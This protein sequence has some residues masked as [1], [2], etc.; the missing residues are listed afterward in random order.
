MS[1]CSVRHVLLFTFLTLCGA[2]TVDLGYA[3][4]RG[5]TLPS[6]V[7]EYLGMRYAAPPL[8]DRRWRAPQD[9]DPDPQAAVQDAD[10]FGASCLGNAPPSLPLA[11]S[12]DCLFVNVFTPANATAG[13]NLPV[14]FFIQGGGFAT[15]TDSVLNGSEV[16]RRSHHRIV[17]VG[18]NYRVGAFGFLASERIRRDGDLNVGLLDQRK[19]LHWAQRYIHLVLSSLNPPWSMRCIG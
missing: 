7:N 4:Y 6:G 8:H 12:E 5:H 3:V 18:I 9:P 15:N 17:L 1:V 14:W 16:V 2:A 10:Q 13:A 11:L 19:A